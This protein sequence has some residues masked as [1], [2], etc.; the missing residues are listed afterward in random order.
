MEKELKEMFAK[1]ESL[2]FTLTRERKKGYQAGRIDKEFLKKRINDFS[3]NFYICGPPEFVKDINSV[4]KA[5]GAKAN[6]LVF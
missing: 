1:K 5:L 6:S 2:I 3:Q 4:L